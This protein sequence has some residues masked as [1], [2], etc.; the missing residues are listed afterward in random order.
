MENRVISLL[1]G[2]AATE[3][4]YGEVDVGANSDIHRVVNIV[5]RFVDNYCSFGFNK[6]E[7]EHSSND[8]RARKENMIFNEMEKYYL[9]AKKIL[10]EN[11]LFLDQLAKALVEKKTLRA[12]DIK[13]IKQQLNLC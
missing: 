12:K 11:K 2:K 3:I 10:R 1:G 9:E 8:L 13:E 4:I 7:I 6:F 5:E